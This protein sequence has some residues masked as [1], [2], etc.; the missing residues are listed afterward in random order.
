MFVDPSIQLAADTVTPQTACNVTAQIQ[1]LE[2]LSVVARML[3]LTVSGVAVMISGQMWYF[4]EHLEH[5]RKVG[6]DIIVRQL[7]WHKAEN[8]TVHVTLVHHKHTGHKPK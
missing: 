6:E 4:R 5:A 1:R 3:W 2:E 8:I 7:S